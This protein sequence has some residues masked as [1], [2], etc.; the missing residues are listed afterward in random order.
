MLSW[1]EFNPIAALT[2]MREFIRSRSWFTVM[3]LVSEKMIKLR[4][5]IRR[6][7]PGR[8][9]ISVSLPI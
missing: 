9:A 8:R 5:Y 7:P 6:N 1:R 3:D 4:A 2:F